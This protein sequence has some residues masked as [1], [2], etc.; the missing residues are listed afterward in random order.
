MLKEGAEKYGDKVRLEDGSLAQ[1]K[2]FSKLMIPKNSTN[3]DVVSSSTYLLYIY[4]KLKRFIIT[5]YRDS[6][7][8][9]HLELFDYNTGKRL[10]TATALNFNDK[11]YTITQYYYQ[12]STNSFLILGLES[13]QYSV[14]AVSFENSQFKILNAYLLSGSSSTYGI[15]TNYCEVG[16]FYDDKIYAFFTVQARRDAAMYICIIIFK[17]ILLQKIK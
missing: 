9:K 6:G 3:I 4:D 16:K 1:W 11:T 5:L 14:L 8:N 2:T 17:I 12:F 13:G 7:D 10:D 15:V